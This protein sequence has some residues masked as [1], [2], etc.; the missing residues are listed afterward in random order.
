MRNMRNTTR[1]IDNNTHT[2][3]NHIHKE[4]EIAENEKEDN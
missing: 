3:T 1:P 2:S 4:N